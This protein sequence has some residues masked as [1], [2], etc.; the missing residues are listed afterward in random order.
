MIEFTTNNPDKSKQYTKRNGAYAVIKNN[1]DLIAIIKTKKGYFLPG[2]GVE[3]GETLEMCL[4]RECLEEIGAEILELNKYSC[5]NHYLCST[6]L[7]IHMENIGHFFT[8][9]I[10]R[11]LEIETEEDHEL[12]WLSHEQATELL[13]LPNQKE[14]VRIIKDKQDDKDNL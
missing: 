1:D 11:F 8:C 6:T 13:Y 4:R 7:N 3:A 10:D 2:G 12:V 9:K 14:A 5:G